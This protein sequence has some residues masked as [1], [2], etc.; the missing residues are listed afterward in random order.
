MDDADELTMFFISKAVFVSEIYLFLVKYRSKRIFVHSDN[1]IF[2]SCSIFL[3]L[4]C[5]PTS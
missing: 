3:S 1:R 2:L 5:L 4:Y